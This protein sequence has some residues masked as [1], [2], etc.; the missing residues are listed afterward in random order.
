MLSAII[1]TLYVLVSLHNKKCLVFL[2]AFLVAEALAYSGLLDSFSEVN[3]Y[4][5]MSAI[6]CSAFYLI[7]L[8]M[9]HIKLLNPCVIFI[10]FNVWMVLDAYFFGEVETFVYSNYESIVCVA[11]LYCLSIFIQW[12]LLAHDLGKGVNM[13]FS[14]FRGSNAGRIRHNI[15]KT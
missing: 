7:R 13:L 4:L 14:G 5:T 3:Y 15:D 12:K 8:R 10:T 9:E 1:L 2:V 11:H 6:Y